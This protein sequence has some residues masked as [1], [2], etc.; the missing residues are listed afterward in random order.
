MKLFAATMALAMLLVPAAALAGPS[1]V[2]NF[3]GWDPADPASE[4][5][6]NGNGVY[7]LTI[8][9]DTLH[10]VY[11]AVDG[12]VW[13]Q[14]F[15]S[16]N[17]EYTVGSPQTVTF[18]CNLGAV[19]GTLQG[20][21]YVFHSLN[22][23]IVCGTLQGALG[24]SNWDQTDTSTTVMS[25]GDGDDVWEFSSVIPTGSYE[26]KIV[27]N[28]NWDQNTSPPG[29]I[30]FGSD[31]VNPVTFKYYMATNTTEV[32]T[33]AAPTVI[34]APIDFDGT[35]A[36][37]LSVQFSKDV[38]QITA[39][40]EANYAITGG[41]S[42]P[43]TVAT[44]TLD[45]SNASLVHLDLATALTEGYDYTVTVT[46]VT[47][48]A[49]TPIDPTANTACFYL[50]RVDFEIN[51][52][53]YI[54]ASGV[55][56]SLHI[57]GDTHPLTWDQCGGAETF[58][59]DAD[60]TYVVTD[61]FTMHYTC[62]AS[63]ESAEVKYKYVVDCTT[64]EGDFEFGHF[65]TLDPNAASQL[66]NVWWED[67][68]PFDNITC[69]VGVLFQVHDSPACAGGL[70]VRGTEAPL[71]WSNGVELLDDGTGGDVTSGDGVFSAQVVFPTGTYKFLE[72]KY[73]CAESDTSGI[74]E[75]DV[76]PNRNLTLDDV[77]GC[78]AIRE[79]PMVL[80]DLWNWCEPVT[81]AAQSIEE[82]SWGQI[83]HIYRAK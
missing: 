53:L 63:A 6:L 25:D 78:M 75:C 39:E 35:A 65:V 45:G 5:T 31:G 34:S 44:A 77:N 23:P 22:P 70:F 1:I 32:I 29:N 12:D 81:G 18:F 14:D 76:L 52:H 30:P 48:L 37:L 80:E 55:P 43:Y 54:A 60:S 16:A 74:Y 49:G 33:A 11:K 62:G 10:V 42:G 2:G 36:D 50:H 69:D 67:V 68:A 71:D 9:S 15:P 21:E 26:F 27:L 56:T 8:T 46:G 51:M 7:E 24:G 59:G 82:R 38:E 72:Y 79:G 13:G 47:D 41:P 61:Y 66:V 64:W 20:D 28:N 73:F 4:L 17:Q 83:K 57:Q 40:T 58:D 19:P 3:Q